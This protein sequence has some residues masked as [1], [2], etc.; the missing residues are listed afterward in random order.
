[1]ILRGGKKRCAR[2]ELRIHCLFWWALRLT[3]LVVT[4]FLFAN[5]RMMVLGDGLVP[6]N[7]Q[8]VFGLMISQMK[9]WH[10]RLEM[11]M[12]F[13]NN[14]EITS[15]L[16]M[17]F[18]YNSDDFVC[19]NFCMGFRI[20]LLNF[21]NKINEC[22]LKTNRCVSLVGLNEILSWKCSEEID[23]FWRRNCLQC[24]AVFKQRLDRWNSHRGQQYR[25]EVMNSMNNCLHEL[26]IDLN[27][28]I[29]RRMKRCQIL[30]KKIV[31]F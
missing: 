25:H 8:F 30:F 17:I 23:R 2:N 28:K 14:F 19:V 3:P 1:M 10:W 7:V 18:C 15:I 13:I 9:F 16:T 20:I 24:K 29:K 11:C 27:V 22:W 6:W 21:V 12:K 4:L 26:P 5:D 31:F